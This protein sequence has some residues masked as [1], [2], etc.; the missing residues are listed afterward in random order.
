M[1]ARS[2][3]HVA[4]AASVLT[5]CSSSDTPGHDPVVEADA[6]GV[7]G[8][9]G[10]GSVAGD[11]KLPGRD[12]TTL[13]DGHVS[14]LCGNS[15]ADIG[16]TCD[17]GNT[18][19]GDGCNQYCKLEDGYVC[20][21][22][23]D[24]CALNVVCGDSKVGPGETCDDGNHVGGDGCSADCHASE[25]GF[26]C[27]T[28]GSA[29]ISTVICGDGHIVGS[30]QCDDGNVTPSDGCS[31]TCQLETG[32]A[33]HVVGAACRA[34]GCGDGIRVGDE[35]CDD[36]NTTTKDGC[37]DHCR[38]ED[39]FVCAADVAL[40]DSCK[41]TS[42]G[43]KKPEGSEQCDDGNTTP[44]DGCFNCQLEP[45]CANSACTPV[46][47]DG[48][49]FPSE[50]CDDG[51]TR[52]GDG[53]SSTCALE[54]GFSC[55]GSTPG[56]SATVVIPVILRDL[57]GNDLGDA[58]DAKGGTVHAHPDFENKNTGETGIVQSLLG[59]RDK[60]PVYA[61][62]DNS[63]ASTSTKAN[64]DRWYNDDAQYNRTSLYNMTLNKSGT[65]YV[66][67][68][69]N[70]FP[71]DAA[72][73]VVEKGQNGQLLEQL[74]AGS[75]GMHNFSFTSEL[76]YWFE[77]K[78][79]EQLNFRGDDDVWVF[80]NGRLA[81]DLGGVHG[82]QDGAVTLSANADAR[83][84]ITVGNI[85]EVVVFQAERHTSASSYKLTLNGFNKVKSSCKS[86]CGDGIVTPDEVCDDGMNNGSYGGCM[87]GCQDFGP[88][89]GDDVVNGAEQ[90][91]LGLNL[92]GHNGCTAECKLGP[93]CG[94]GN[95]D[96]AFG[97]MCDDGANDGGY[98]ECAAG[99]VLGP[100]CGDGIT[101]GDESCDDGNS[102]AYD[103]CDNACNSTIVI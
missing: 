55:L 101:N 74:R 54:T 41:K 75:G 72:G 87:P 42:C 73:F 94:D 31:A 34:A 23:G 90:C 69:A 47:G 64:F 13:H 91:D 4:L 93:R 81:V 85:Y 29:C 89:C 35:L 77:Y 6:S 78:G 53:C 50:A 83:F 84:A 45:S 43:D 24:R 15:V 10:D 71:L 11:A 44:Y 76:R 20:A 97:E 33:C 52:S 49:K 7:D 17:D 21:A 39:G 66:F 95:V 103:G 51:N 100:R 62:A 65:S 98:G 80:V 30:E 79:G 59:S 9:A 38:P 88:R 12:A 58:T 3:L 36:G 48:I 67:D 25:T 14:P 16:E 56:S 1:S 82:A 57:R 99:C 61:K 8:G 96:G 26:N 70:F 18:S 46:C 5:A 102:V 40:K 2:L 27:A 19:A 60:K 68:N 37:D 22:A 28:P 32:F 63:S 92:G 86:T